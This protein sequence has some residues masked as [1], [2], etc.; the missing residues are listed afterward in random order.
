L[1]RHPRFDNRVIVYDLDSDP[2][3]LFDLDP[4]AIAGRL[5]V[6][7]TDLPGGQSR[8]PL[9]EVHLN[10]C[11]SL[12]Q[13]EHLR[14]EDFSRLHIDPELARERAGRVRASGPHI[15]EK[16]RQVF[17]AT[18]ERE[19]ADP[20]AALYDGFLADGDKRRCAQVRSTSPQ[21]LGTREFGFQDP[22][23]PELLFRYRARNWPETL[24]AGERLRWDAYRRERLLA[25]SGLS[26]LGLRQYREQIAG[27]RTTHAGEGGKLA[28][29]DQLQAWGDEL[30]ST[31]MER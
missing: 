10:R 8:I 11:P 1:A 22:R 16:I 17:A 23:L 19:P 27:M 9:K 30:Q 24:D 13:W 2:Q 3:P 21:A 28:L 26:E 12:V 5:F 29:L 20:D 4:G 14:A 7:A 18:Q 25:D 6:R 31:L 15:A